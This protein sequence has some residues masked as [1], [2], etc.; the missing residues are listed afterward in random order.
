M[1]HQ[2]SIKCQIELVEID[3]LLNFEEFVMFRQAAND[4]FHKM[5]IVIILECQFRH[6]VGIEGGVLLQ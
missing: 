1:L 2:N 4:I 5:M 3:I 6:N